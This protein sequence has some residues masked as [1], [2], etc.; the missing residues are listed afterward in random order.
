MLSVC[1]PCPC[2]SVPGQSS[3]IVRRVNRNSLIWL[4]GPHSCS[5]SLCPFGLD[6]ALP[7]HVCLSIILQVY[8][9][10]LCVCVCHYMS[11]SAC[12]GI[13]IWYCLC[14]QV[15]V[16][17]H[18][19][20]CPYISLW[21]FVCMCVCISLSMSTFVCMYIC[22]HI[23]IFVYICSYLF[24]W[25]VNVFVFI[26]PCLHIFVYVCMCCISLSM[27]ISMW[28]IF[29]VWACLWMSLLDICGCI[30]VKTPDTSISHSVDVVQQ[31]S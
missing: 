9:G 27:C 21:V 10:C 7:V 25:P 30:C 17:L 23:D 4:S 8:V 28:P 11:L 20:I 26:W 12:L 5:L 29:S 6:I 24:L 2:L 14:M 19:S 3:R 15:C 18:V 16:P 22:A 31:M 13:S 1:C